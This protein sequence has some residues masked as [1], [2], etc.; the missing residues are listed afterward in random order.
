M[1]NL[2]KTGAYISN[3]IG[4][5]IGDYNLIEDKDKILVGVSGGKDS[6]SLLAL[7]KERQR[8]APVKY[9]LFAAHISTDFACG[10]CGQKEELAK[11]FEGMGVRAQF[12]KIAVLDEEGKTDCFWCSWSR[13]KALFDIAGQLG[14]NKIALGHHK[15]DIVETILLNL[16]FNGEIS[17]MNPSQE[18][19]EG[20]LFIIRP[21]CYCEE[22]ALVEFAAES[23]F[24]PHACNCPYGEVSS[25]RYLKDLIRDMEARCPDVKENIF[26]SISRV[27]KDYI[28][29]KVEK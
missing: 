11:F 6:R 18:L 17:A 29:L 21:L 7:L 26:R 8:W 1:R 19:F 24:A 14:C 20:K 4:K 22:S 13:R 15:D 2:S 16:F 28:D 25:R 12:K 27:R 23:N 9:E 5:A 3:K 10:G